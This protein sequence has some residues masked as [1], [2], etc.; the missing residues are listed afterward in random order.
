MDAMML[1]R[2]DFVRQLLI[3]RGDLLVVSGLGSATYD[4]AAAEAAVDNAGLE[5]HAFEDGIAA[6]FPTELG[7]GAW[8][9]VEQPS[10]LPWRR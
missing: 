1:D 8:L 10:A 4:V 2:R 3:D 7:E 6:A 9:F 5:W